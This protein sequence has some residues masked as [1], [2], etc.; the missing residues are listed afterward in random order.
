MNRFLDLRAGSRIEFEEV[1]HYFR[2][3]VLTRRVGDAPDG[4]ALKLAGGL[5]LS[6]QK[7]ALDYSAQYWHLLGI[8]H[9]VS[10]R[11]RV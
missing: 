10:F 2:E 9:G 1:E 6:I 4:N 5:S 11:W 3:H 7:F 8:V